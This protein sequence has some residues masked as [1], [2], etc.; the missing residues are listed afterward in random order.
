MPEVGFICGECSGHPNLCASTE[1]AMSCFSA[2]LRNVLAVPFSHLHVPLRGSDRD[3]MFGD[4]GGGAGTPV[5]SYI[6]EV[7]TTWSWSM[8]F[9]SESDLIVSIFV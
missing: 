4:D 5:N 2:G 8:G 7:G 3:G 9:G 6:R 1:M